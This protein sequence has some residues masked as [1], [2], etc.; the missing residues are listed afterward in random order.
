MNDSIILYLFASMSV[1]S[2]IVS[3]YTHVIVQRALKNNDVPPGSPPQTPTLPDK[4]TS[5]Q[6]V[7]VV[8]VQ[9]A[10]KVDL[11]QNNVWYLEVT[12]IEGT[13]YNIQ[14]E[15][16]DGSSDIENGIVPEEETFIHPKNVT[17]T[18]IVGIPPHG[19]VGVYFRWELNGFHWS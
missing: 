19:D 12:G 13:P 17:P 15:W 11:T 18:K 3:I 6:N 14:V 7:D 1:I 16:S 8:E 2:L 9:P 10:P 4:P 5:N